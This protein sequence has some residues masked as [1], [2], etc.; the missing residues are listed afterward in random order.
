MTLGNVHGEMFM[1]RCQL[2]RIVSLHD[3]RRLSGGT[4]L[5]A[6]PVLTGGAGSIIHGKMTNWWHRMSHDVVKKGVQ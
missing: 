4:G 1:G 6:A 2:L 3:G 5:L